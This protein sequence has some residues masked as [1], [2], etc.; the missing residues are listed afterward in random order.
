MF[1]K[2]C[3]VEIEDS[4]RVCPLC[5][6]PLDGKDEIFPVVKRTKRKQI[7]TFSQIFWV[8]ALMAIIPCL[9]VNFALKQ[10]VLWSVAIVGVFI[11]LYVLIAMTFFSKSHVATKI[12][13]L[14]LALAILTG[15]LQGLTPTVTWAANYAVPI[16][17]MV[18]A[19]QLGIAS[20]VSKKTGN[21]LFSLFFVSLSGLIPIIYTLAGKEPMLI[22]SIVC[23]SVCGFELLVL[24]IWGLTGGKEIIL[25][26]IKR[27]FN[28]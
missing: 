4:S 19:I 21:F 7:I 18:G 8:V 1:C 11:Y 12:L 10:E 9:A 6:A 24:L 23:A 17:I 26:E 5:H 14:T 20:I 28:A 15:C 16:V 13:I 25:S 2:N 27:K 3:K 22:P